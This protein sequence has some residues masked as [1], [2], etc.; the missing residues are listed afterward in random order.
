VEK[1]A[2]LSIEVK[3]K[4]L[5]MKD[6]GD[7]PGKKKRIS[8]AQFNG[9]GQTGIYI[10]RVNRYFLKDFPKQEGEGKGGD[11]ASNQCV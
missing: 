3:G 2:F 9:Q 10:W 4:D 8:W 7:D 6:N 11:E 1:R 5:Q